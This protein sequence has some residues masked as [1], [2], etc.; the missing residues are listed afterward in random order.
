[1]TFNCNWLTWR[2]DDE[3]INVAMVSAETFDFLTSLPLQPSKTKQKKKK[4]LNITKD[5]GDASDAGAPSERKTS[6]FLRG[7]CDITKMP[8]NIF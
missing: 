2:R 1:M 5:A 4:K 7:Q 3:L 8:R 6:H